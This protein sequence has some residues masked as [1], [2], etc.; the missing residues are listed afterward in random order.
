MN[1]GKAERTALFLVLITTNACVLVLLLYATGIRI[2]LTPSYPI[3]FYR[4]ANEPWHKNDLVMACL[5][6]NTAV[7][8]IDRGYLARS[9]NCE[10]HTPVL[11][12]VLAVAGDHVLV[13]DQVYVNGQP[14]PNTRLS[15]S[16]SSGR[17][18]ESAVGGETRHHDVWLLSDHFQSSFDSRYFGAIRDSLILFKV[19]PVWTF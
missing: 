2:N 14:I 3:G 18:L 9:R 1:R 13:S 16:D 11:K 15:R 4:K 6:K 17:A 10:G 7:M 12:K 8:A 19:V 5:P